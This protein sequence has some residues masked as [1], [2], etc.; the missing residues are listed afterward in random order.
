MEVKTRKEISSSTVSGAVTPVLISMTRASAGR[1]V[2]AT[3]KIY[4]VAMTSELA[5][6][7]GLSQIRTRNECFLVGF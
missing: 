7:S 5:G 4:G 3:S 2:L 1:R 6:I